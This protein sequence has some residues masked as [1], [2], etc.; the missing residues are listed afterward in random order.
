MPIRWRLTAFNALTIGTVLLLL[1]AALF[2][3]LREVLLS[4]IEDTARDRALMAARAVEA[5]EPLSEEETE[6]LTFGGVFVVVRDGQGRVL[7]R[8]VSL[9][10]LE[11]E[12]QDDVWRRALK[13][14]E[15]V[16]GSA[17]LSPSAPDYVYAVP[18]DTPDGE[19]RV[20]EA[21]RSYALARETLRDF[22]GVLAAGVLATLALS[23]GGAY[24]LARAA[25]S[26]VNAIVAS[27]RRISESDLG[28]RLP[29]ANPED[30][31]GR[32]AT[33]MNELLA[34]LE[35]AF[36]RR[37]EALAR[38][39]RFAADAGH[40]LRTPLTSIAGYAWMLEEWGLE[41][42]RAARE[43]VAAIRREA[44][45]MKELSEN[46]LALA[47]GDE[48]VP[49]SPEPWDLRAVAAEA[50]EASRA[51]ANGK[52]VLAYVPPEDPVE[53]CF[54]RL[55]VRQAVA[56]LLDNAVKYTPQ[57]KIAV[58]VG[59]E[60]GW[61][62]L[63]VSDTGVGIPEEHLP[64]VFKRFYRVDP[65][66]TENGAGLGL[67]IARQIARAHGGEIEAESEPGKGSTF[68]LRIPRGDP[69]R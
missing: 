36:S 1:A 49:M 50:V 35:S 23:V 46:L 55:R 53:A 43:G 39:R 29:V 31:I 47:R 12:A 26:P 5:G 16:G 25:L 40:E 42:Q 45:R 57:G 10:A 30:E 63:E 56:I 68:V 58:A 9:V 11:E 51:A 37:E 69:A 28:R 65:A 18:V 32:L 4:G 34:R 7:E 8:T 15:P 33:T 62:W 38:Q 24:L 22:A 27:A 14:G 66:R 60:D 2:F 64:L 20:V 67:S 6:Q 3:L 19:V 41:D 61:V 48:G 17:S 21:G 59:E 44:D 54:D 52:V 13:T